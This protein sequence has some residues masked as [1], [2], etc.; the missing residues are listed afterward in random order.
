MTSTRRSDIQRVLI[1]TLVANLIVAAAK[2]TIGL[3]SG[4]LAM[5]ADGVHSSLDGTSNVIGLIG[6]VLA[7]RPPD[8]GH[9]YGHRRFETL[10]SMMIGGILLLTG[11]ELIKSGIERLGTQEAP[12]VGPL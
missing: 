6:N 8:E 10:A 5:V 7:G 11:W 2:I 9:P 4:S 1:I 3:I 12:E